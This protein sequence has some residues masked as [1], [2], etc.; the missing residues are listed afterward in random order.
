[1]ICPPVFDFQV[2]CDPF[3]GLMTQFCARLLGKNLRRQPFSFVCGNLLKHSYLLVEIGRVS[4]W[5]HAYVYFL[6]KINSCLK[7]I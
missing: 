6:S 4:D 5:L 3:V 2:L 1:M 7:F